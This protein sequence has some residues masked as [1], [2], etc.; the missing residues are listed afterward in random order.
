M[1]YEKLYNEIYA[2]VALKYLWRGYRPGYV[3]NESPDW[4]NPDQS[5]G[6]EVSQALLPYDGQDSSFLE[7]W[8]GRLSEEIPAE[9]KERYAGRLYFYN[10]RLWA[11]LPDPR[12]TRSWQEKA[13][14][15]FCRKHEKL[16]KNFAVCKINALYLYAHATPEK[17]EEVRRIMAEMANSQ[18]GNGVKFD[19]VFLDCESC[20]YILDF[21]SGGIAEMPV[22]EQA[23]KF[24]EQQAERIRNAENPEDN[25][26]F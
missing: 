25:F 7:A 17:T 16:N 4:L 20:I 12:D 1:A 13:H 5:V 10:D 23:K 19:L 21:R 22:G 26:E 15:R 2:I 9:A 3:K 8:L 24:L 6:I 14:Y 11:L 18:Q